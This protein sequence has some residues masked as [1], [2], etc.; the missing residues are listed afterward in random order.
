[1]KIVIAGAGDVGF[2]LAEL[3]SIENIDIILIDLEQDV[4]DYAATHLD[5]LTL[6]GDCASIDL[7]EQ[8]QVED[9]R[10]FLAVTTSEKTNLVASILAKKL[11]AKQVIARVDNS[12]YLCGEQKEIFKE[13]GI[14]I[15]MSPIQLAANEI[16]RLI[17]RCN[18]TDLFEFEKGKINLAGLT[19]RKD[20]PLVD[21]KVKDLNK[22]Q[23]GEHLR[24]IAILRGHETIIPKGD[25]IL[26][27]N[28]HIYFLTK[29]ENIEELES[30][31]G[32]RRKDIKRIMIIGGDKLSVATAQILEKNYQVTL[33]VKDKKTAIE[34]SEILHST[35]I[36]RGDYSN[37]ELLKEEGLGNMDAFLA[38]TENSE[39][40]IIASLTAK[41]YGVFK[42]IAQVENKEY[43]HL[44]QNIGVDTL[45][46][47]KLIAANNIFRFVRKGKI[48]AVTSLH[49]VDAEVIEFV[50]HKENRTTRHPIKEL[51]FPP[52]AIIGGVI[53]GEDSLLPDGN[54]Q[55]QVGDKVVVFSLP[56]SIAK[57]EKIFS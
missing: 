1:M 49:G 46:N 17:Q 15:L 56:E 29:R 45:I 2:H 4:L 28:D 18:F 31:L 22:V 14:D 13:L 33:I 36:I 23:K 16:E 50:I 53:R 35:L 54:F 51:H 20:S 47:K 12:E 52:T 30:I 57:L 9:A 48:E 10:L 6:R 44:S 55:L 32:E 38:L 27:S 42:T 7:L 37:V 8:A 25:T 41:N 21:T 26:K 19:L 34:L 5:V 24:P 39:T 3:L 43:I 11:G 40:N